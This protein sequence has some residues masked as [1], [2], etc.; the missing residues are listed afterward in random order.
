MRALPS[1]S[2]PLLAMIVRVDDVSAI[3][4]I[5][6]YLVTPDPATEATAVRSK[7]D[8]VIVS[9]W[10]LG[11]DSREADNAFAITSA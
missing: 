6:T 7:T 4:V 5:T 11:A 8:A 9:P 1:Q 10:A 2:L 3:S